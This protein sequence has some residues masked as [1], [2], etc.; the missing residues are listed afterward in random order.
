MSKSKIDS[1]RIKIWPRSTDD[2]FFIKVGSAKRKLLHRYV[3]E[4]YY[5][6]IPEGFIV[7]HKNENK[8]CN[9]ITNL[10]LITLSKHSIMHNGGC[11]NGRAKAVICLDTNTIFQT[12]RDAENA[13]H[14]KGIRGC[15]YGNQ[16][17]SGGY[18]WAYYEEENH[19]K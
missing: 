5:G 4:L 15:L 2:Y 17:T 19:A 3:W 10:E 12:I 18:H 14:V 13:I 11:L 7:H 9:C 6:P 8:K 1:N 16:K